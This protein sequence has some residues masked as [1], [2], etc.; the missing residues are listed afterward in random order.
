MIVEITVKDQNLLVHVHLMVEASH[1][2]VVHGQLAEP[3]ATG[4]QKAVIRNA[5]LLD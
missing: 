5:V 4:H 2:L 3:L 1:H